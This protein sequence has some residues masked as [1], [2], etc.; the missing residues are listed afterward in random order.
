MSYK[1]KIGQVVEMVRTQEFN[2]IKA[3]IIRCWVRNESSVKKVLDLDKSKDGDLY[4]VVERHMKD[5][6]DLYL[7]KSL[8]TEEFTLFGRSGLRERK[9]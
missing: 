3:G 6:H 5:G 8:K 1:F 7:C 2:E 4:E 9:T